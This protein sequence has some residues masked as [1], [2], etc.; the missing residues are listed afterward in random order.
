MTAPG[1]EGANTVA[2]ARA[3]E[4]N[5][6]GP[7]RS[8]RIYRVGRVGMAALFLLCVFL[9]LRAPLA[10]A[11]GQALAATPLGVAR[12]IAGHLATRDRGFVL[13]TLA[14]RELGM[15]AVYS[16]LLEGLRV[17]F[18]LHNSELMLRALN[19]RHTHDYL[20]WIRARDDAKEGRADP[21]DVAKK[22]AAAEA[23]RL[24]LY[25]ERTRNAILRD[26]LSAFTGLSLPDELVDPPAPPND[27][28]PQV[29]VQAILAKFSMTRADPRVRRKVLQSVLNIKDAWQFAV[30]ARARLD[31]L[32]KNLLR[33][34]EIYQQG[35]AASLGT[36]MGK[37][38]MGEAEM[39]RAA[40][41][42][43]IN[44]YVLSV[45]LGNENTDPK[46]PTFKG[47]DPQFLYRLTGQ[48]KGEERGRYVPKSGTGFGQDDA[49]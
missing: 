17:Y 1:E 10:F 28:P 20:T 6:R 2:S 25:R 4:G 37:V 42:Y 33:A 12:Q 8:L 38:T 27:K 45:L 19:E 35:R 26:R 36:A 32:R 47:L 24:Q 3:F 9:P 49:Q 29:D 16:V 18:D 11:Q 15:S 23:S 13:A 40:K 39:V 30:A 43:F 34:Q 31:Y 41:A 22:L 5:F 46:Q 48:K 44:V 14:P 7:S 21:V